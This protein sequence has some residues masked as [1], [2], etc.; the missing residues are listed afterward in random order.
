MTRNGWRPLPSAAGRARARSVPEPENSRTMRD[1]P[2]SAGSS[3]GGA[4]R[5]AASRG[6]PFRTRSLGLGK[7]GD[8]RHPGEEAL[9]R[10][11]VPAGFTPFGR[12]LEVGQRD[13]I[14][15]AVRTDGG[16]AERSQVRAAAELRAEIVGEGADVGPGRTRGFEID[17]GRPEIPEIEPEDGDGRRR[18]AEF[19]AGPGHL[20]DRAAG[21]LLGR[22]ARR[23]LEDVPHEGGHGPGEG[24]AGWTIGALRGGRRSR[25]RRRCPWRIRGGCG[26]RRPF[27]P[28]PGR[29]R[30]GSPGPPP[31]GGRPSRPGRASRRGRPAA[32]PGAGGRAGRRRGRSAPRACR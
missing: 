16:P 7:H 32:C 23:G 2:G 1:E 17:E 12:F 31:R 13:G 26:P 28:P 29:G 20:V 15:E 18:E 10:H 22:E 8:G 4:A 30:S 14:R 9:E 24:F 5:W 6:E 11:D 25:R 21:Q 3:G 27:S 19:L